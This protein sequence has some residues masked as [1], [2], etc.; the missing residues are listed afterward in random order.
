MFGVDKMKRY[1]FRVFLLI[2]ADGFSAYERTNDAER[3]EGGDLKTQPPK[4]FPVGLCSDAKSRRIKSIERL[5]IIPPHARK[6]NRFFEKKGTFRKSPV[7]SAKIRRFLTRRTRAETR[8][9][10]PDMRKRTYWT[11]RTDWT[12]RSY[13]SNWSYL[14]FPCW[15]H[16]ATAFVLLI[17]SRG[18]K[19]MRA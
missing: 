14:R 3:F 17:A 12:H 18:Q 19:K 7:K 8:L 10:L 1:S 2:R 9:P 15:D 6:I 5:F 13:L 11:D 16:F 4:I